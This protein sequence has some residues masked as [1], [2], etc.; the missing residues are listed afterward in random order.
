MMRTQSRIV[1]PA[2][3]EFMRKRRAARLEDK[4]E[5]YA[6]LIK[7]EAEFQEET[8][9]AIFKEIEKRYDLKEGHFQT[10]LSFY[11]A[12]PRTS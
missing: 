4:M 8:N 1:Y 6:R 12:D 9:A 7:E 2:T 5:D 10:I 11:S 3:L